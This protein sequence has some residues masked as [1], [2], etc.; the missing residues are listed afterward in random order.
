[1]ALARAVPSSGLLARFLAPIAGL[2]LVAWTVWPVDPDR[3]VSGEFHG[4]AQVLHIGDGLRVRAEGTGTWAGTSRSPQL[5]WDS[6]RLELSAG[7]ELLTGVAVATPEARLH[8]DSGEAVVLR[9]SG[10]TV[11]W[12]SGGP[13]T[14]TCRGQAPE[15]LTPGRMGRCRA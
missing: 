1:M 14:L 4:E 6:G 3:A 12:A 11:I 10:E 9:E 7:S 8:L 15:R 13:L 5:Y 2:G